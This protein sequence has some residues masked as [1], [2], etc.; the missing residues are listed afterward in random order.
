[1]YDFSVSIGVIVY[2]FLGFVNQSPT[3][4]LLARQR[5]AQFMITYLFEGV[6]LPER[7]QI[8][9]NFGM[10]F[11]HLTTE[12]Q[13]TA[14]ISIVLNQI[15]IWIDSKI[16]WNI[17]DLRNVVKNIVLNEIAIVGYL[18]GYAYEVE[19]RRI[20]QPELISIMCLVL[21]FP[22]SLSVTKLLIFQKKLRRFITKQLAKMAFFY[23]DVSMTL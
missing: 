9:L 8:S 6:V 16:E 19:I 13:A 20:L 22:A 7:A 5:K 1:M 21:K 17:F 14:R 10:A 11:E 3:L 15:A 18:R 12:T 23:I 2:R 4:K